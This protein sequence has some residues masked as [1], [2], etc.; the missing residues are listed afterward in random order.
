MNDIERKLINDGSE[1]KR[2]KMN[3]IMV[4]IGLII[5]IISIIKYN[6]I[7]NK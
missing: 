5:I 6:L 1:N 7:K 2:T 4:F 3:L